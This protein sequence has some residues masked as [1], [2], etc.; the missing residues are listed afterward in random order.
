M[1]VLYFGGAFNSGSGL[2]A[3]IE[4]EDLLDSTRGDQQYL[5]DGHPL[6]G[7]GAVVV[8]ASMRGVSSRGRSRS[9]PGK[10]K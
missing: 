8:G 2:L 9:Q 7:C 10:Y 1:L 4:E 6:S 5:D 3:K